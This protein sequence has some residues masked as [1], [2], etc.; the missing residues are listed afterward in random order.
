[1]LI[2]NLPFETIPFVEYTDTVYR[3]MSLMDENEI[4]HIAVQH[5]DKFEG[6]LSEEV[7]LEV[8]E[9]STVSEL[10]H[11]F[12][13]IS[14]NESDHFLKAVSLAAVYDLS[15]VPVTDESRSLTGTIV[16]SHLL[17]FVA[18][19]MH[20][21]E[22]GGM[23]VLEIDPLHY[24]ISEISKI[25]ESND[26]QITQLNSSRHSDKGSLQVTIKINKLEISDIVS[27]FQRY[28]YNVIY[29]SGEELYTNEL[30][31]NYE[32]LMNYLNI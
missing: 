4:S 6:I 13:D 27:S 21:Q 24:S 26:A 14:A 12:L 3:V 29:Y 23:I 28:E 30:K 2:K 32:N 25:I 31:S 5:N 22:P 17:R 20:I 19:F 15:I 18:D 10:Q 8:D 16:A 11:L 9:E 7:L 1:M